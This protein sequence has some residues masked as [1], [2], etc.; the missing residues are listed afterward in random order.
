MP[1]SSG[2][3]A[4]LCL[5]VRREETGIVHYLHTS[6]GNYNAT[7]ARLYT[8]IGLFTADPKICAEAARLFNA[9]TGYAGGVEYEELLV[10]PGRMR[11]RLLSRIERE[12][13]CHRGDGAGYLAMEMNALV[14]AECIMALY[15]AS[16][17]GVQIDLQVRGICCLR[18]GVEGVSENI[19]VRSIV[20]RFWS[21]RA[22]TIS[23]T[24]ATRSCSSAV[25]TSC[26]E[27]SITASRCCCRSA[28]RKCA[29]EFG[30]GS[31]QLTWRTTST[32][33]ILLRMA[34]MFPRTRRAPD[35]LDSHRWM[36]EHRGTWMS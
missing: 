15:R 8:D 12:I 25:P 16:Q 9:L 13:E 18:P 2:L 36:I 33:G 14:D 3:Y 17:A 29:P 26:R 23:A 10:A 28:T 31:W 22:S 35:K 4:K 20:G 6:T 1:T 27:T 24:A 34:S 19:R 30:D 21:T 5:V 11:E 32:H 7:T